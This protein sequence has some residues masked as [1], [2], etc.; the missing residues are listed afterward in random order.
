MH[1][2][3]ANQDITGHATYRD[4]EKYEVE[5]KT[6]TKS[7][8]AA[9]FHPFKRSTTQR[10][11]K[12]SKNPSRKQVTRVSHSRNNGNHGINNSQD[13]SLHLI[14]SDNQYD[15]MSINFKNQKKLPKKKFMGSNSKSKLRAGFDSGYES[16]SVYSVISG[17]KKLNFY[18][19][20]N[21]GHD[22]NVLTNLKATSRSSAHDD[23]SGKDEQEILA[24]SKTTQFK[25][26]VDKVVNV[27][28]KTPYKVIS[29]S[30]ETRLKNA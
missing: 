27:Y 29:H 6:Q 4:N 28:L 20:K 7:K 10:E 5:Y 9:A 17:N 18:N 22:F 16:G 13:S 11:E 23:Y 19:R 25:K 21:D 2:I 14:Q 30:N 15:M 24:K 3:K 1:G 26:H 12:L 8:A